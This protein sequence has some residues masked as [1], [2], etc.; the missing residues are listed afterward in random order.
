MVFIVDH[1]FTEGL[2]LLVI[3][4]IMSANVSKDYRNV[5]QQCW[6]L[7]RQLC[8]LNIEAVEASRTNLL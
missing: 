2:L 8:T 6:S 5:G 7:P 1:V 3:S 4:V